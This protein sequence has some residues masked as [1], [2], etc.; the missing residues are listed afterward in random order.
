MLNILILNIFYQNKITQKN[1]YQNYFLNI[2]QNNIDDLFY[3]INENAEY[4]YHSINP[5]DNLEIIKNKIKKSHLIDINFSNLQ[6]INLNNINFR[7]LDRDGYVLIDDFEIINKSINSRFNIK[8][9]ANKDWF[10][11][12]KNSDNNFHIFYPIKEIGSLMTSLSQIK[13][14]KK[15]F[16]NMPDDYKSSLDIKLENNQVFSVEWFF[17]THI[18]HIGIARFN[19]DII[20]I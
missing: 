9:I 15:I 1:Q 5:K 19:R 8:N 3:R 4:I 16:K 18:F 6:R 10:I 7:W 2:S 12:I 13:L 11:F 14:K 17:L 20:N